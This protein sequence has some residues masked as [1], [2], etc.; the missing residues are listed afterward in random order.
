MLLDDDVIKGLPSTLPASQRSIIVFIIEYKQKDAL[1]IPGHFSFV[2]SERE[3]VLC[4]PSWLL[5]GLTFV[6]EF[7]SGYTGKVPG[8]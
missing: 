7:R 2:P 3:H 8:H 5:L 1:S 4:F 6:V